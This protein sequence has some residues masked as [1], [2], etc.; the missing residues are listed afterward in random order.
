MT[1]DVIETNCTGK[2]DNGRLG[3]GPG[4]TGNLCHVDCSNRGLCDYKTGLCKCFEGHY[5]DDCSLRSV[6][7][8][9]MSRT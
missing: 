5:G 6:L 1:V 8:R 9:D 7:A 2:G 4:L 3:T